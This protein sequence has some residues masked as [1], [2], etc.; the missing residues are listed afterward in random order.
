MNSSL[1]TNNTE[2]SLARKSSDFNQLTASVS[3]LTASLD[4][5]EIEKRQVE[6]E[7]DM[8]AGRFKKIR[9]DKKELEAF[10]KTRLA[11]T[12]DKYMRG[13]QERDDKL[14]QK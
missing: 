7:R 13:L 2:T 5:K 14:K 12:K 6:D 8:M 11:A 10:T 4:K 1:I 3:E 9:S